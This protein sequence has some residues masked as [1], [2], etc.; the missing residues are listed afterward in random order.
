[1]YF[2]R[3]N[4]AASPTN[5]PSGWSGSLSVASGCDSSRLRRPNR[6]MFSLLFLLQG[7]LERKD[8][9]ERWESLQSLANPTPINESGVERHAQVVRHDRHRKI[10]A[11]VPPQ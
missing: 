5:S 9:L 7:S 6:P 2:V 8:D 4:R 1:M 3:Y 10:R 11:P